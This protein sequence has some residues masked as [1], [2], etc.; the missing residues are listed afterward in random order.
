M[1]LVALACGVG[2]VGGGPVHPALAGGQ[3]GGGEV[4]ERVAGLAAGAGVGDE[5]GVDPPDLEQVL[6]LVSA[7]DDP[8]WEERVLHAKLYPVKDRGV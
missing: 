1:P 5:G 6:A 3:L 4:A 8:W 2:E 7:P